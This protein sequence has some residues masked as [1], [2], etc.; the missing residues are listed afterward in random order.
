MSILTDSRF[1]YGHRPPDLVAQSQDWES[2]VTG[3]SDGNLLPKIR[4]KSL[5]LS[6]LWIFGR[7]PPEQTRLRGLMRTPFTREKLQDLI[8]GAQKIADDLLEGLKGA[9]RMDLVT[10]FAFPLTLRVISGAIG[11]PTDLKAMRRWARDVS[12][13]LAGDRLPIDEEKG[14]FAVAGL[15]E[16]LR[17]TIAASDA[18][19]GGLLDFLMQASAD[20]KLTRDEVL[21]NCAAMLVAGHA[22]TQ[23]TIGNGML[24]LLKHPAQLQLLREN[25]SLCKWSG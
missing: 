3:P 14:L 18:R 20:E 12:S 13:R 21:A 23:H 2:L 24:L 4:R 5:Q 25:P 9:S 7:N 19:P 1:A 15:A 8:L 10:D 6:E 16:F 17:K 11:V 22:T